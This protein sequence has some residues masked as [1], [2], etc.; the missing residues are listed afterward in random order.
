MSFRCCAASIWGRTGAVVDTT[1][2]DIYIATGNARYD[3]RIHWGDA[4]VS[5]DSTG[6]SILDNYTPTN[7]D[8]LNS[9][10]ADLGSTSP[11][12]V[13]NGYVIQGWKDGRI[14]LLQWGRARNGGRRGGE[15][16]IVSTPSGD[17]LFT[18]PAVVHGMLAGI[19][20]T[21]ESSETPQN[22]ELDF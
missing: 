12:L 13:G 10:D 16:Q 3:G 19:G 17:D 14:R 20:L 22:H 9:R 2:G 4:A 1:T 11:A 5:I 8:D 6:T 18:S 15:A 21:Q 7:T